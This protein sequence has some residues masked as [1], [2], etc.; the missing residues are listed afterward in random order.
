MRFTTYE[1]WT[2]LRRFQRE[3]DRAW[4][5]DQANESDAGEVTWRP[6]VDISENDARWLLAAELPGVDKS[7]INITAEDGF[8]VIEGEKTTVV[9]DNDNQHRA[10]RITG[11]FYRR[12]SLPKGADVQNITATSKNGVLTLS[13]PKQPEK[14]PQR[15]Q[16]EA[17]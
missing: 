9:E 7:D 16:I 15:I 3:L 5:T 8:L 1:P 2:P 13:I 12:F 11:R 4:R 10:E 6:S 14:V 17:A